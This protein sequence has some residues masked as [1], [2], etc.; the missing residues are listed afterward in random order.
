MSL[1][2]NAIIL[3]V[4]D[5]EKSKTFYSDGMGCPIAQNHGI[6]VALE[7]GNGPTLGLFQLDAL[8]GDSGVEL[9]GDGYRSYTLNFHA[10]SNEEVD[11][12]MDQAQRAGATVVKAAE[13]AQ[14]G[15]YFGYFAD[16]DGHLW[17]VATA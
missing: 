8:A 6:F 7:L 15:G 12:V 1:A 2:V 13:A 3:G 9:A 5:M 16:P 10:S 11:S 17:K 4:K 14:W